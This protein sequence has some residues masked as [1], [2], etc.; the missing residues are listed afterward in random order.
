VENIEADP[1][2]GIGF[3]IPSFAADLIIERDPLSGLPLSASIE[4]GVLPVAVL[5]ELGVVG[6]VAFVGW[7]MLLFRVIL[8]RGF[9]PLSV[10]ITILMINLGESTLFSPGGMGMLSL[11]LI[12]WAVTHTRQQSRQ[13]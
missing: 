11:V 6:F 1:F 13:T 4:K 3:G 7:L 5:E 12:G 10:V 2:I 9:A 8:H